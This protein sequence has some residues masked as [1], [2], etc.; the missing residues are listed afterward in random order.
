MRDADKPRILDSDPA[1]GRARIQGPSRRRE[2]NATSPSRGSR[3]PRSTRS[4]KAARTSSMP[5]KTAGFSSFSTPPRGPPRWPTAARCAARPSCIKCRTTPLSQGPSPRRRAS[6]PISGAT[7]RCVRCKAISRP[8]ADPARTSASAGTSRDR[9]WVAGR[10]SCGP[11]LNFVHQCGG[12]EAP[13][14]A[15]DFAAE[16]EAG[17]ALASKMWA[18]S[19]RF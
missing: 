12:F 17:A 19:F 11:R 8:P 13:K 16:L 2:P 18:A 6:R 4:R 14:T 7:S 15:G 1:A 10:T 3:R 9:I 5:S